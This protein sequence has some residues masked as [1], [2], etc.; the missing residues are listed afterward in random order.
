MCGCWVP[1]FSRPAAAALFPI[2]PLI[3]PTPP[4]T[5]FLPLALPEF[6][7]KKLALESPESWVEPR[8]RGKAGGS[9]AMDVFVRV[10]PVFEGRVLVVARLELHCVR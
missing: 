4:A 7:Q 5:C 3:P 8:A 9:Y 10:R 6:L 2:L 1:D